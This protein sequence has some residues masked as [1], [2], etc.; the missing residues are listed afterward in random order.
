[1]PPGSLYVVATPLGNLEDITLRALRV[2]K[3]VDWVAAE[4]T[5]HTRKLFSHYGIRTPLI[6][7]HDWVEREKAPRL[8]ER[9]A[10]GESGALVS[11]AGTPGLSDPGFHLVR[12]AWAAGVRVVPVPGPSAVIAA[13]SAAGLP[14]QRFVFEG[15]LPARASSRRARLQELANE[16]RTLVL[17]ETARRLGSTLEDMANVWGGRTVVIA[18]ELTKRFE[19][20]LRGT[21]AEL[22]QKIGERRHEVRGEVTIVAE[23][24]RRAACAPAAPQDWQTALADLLARGVS[25]RDAARKVAQEY[26]ITRREVY[27][28]GLRQH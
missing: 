17:F 10:G 16:P 18:R 4:D 5:R 26:G 24:A 6:A 20:F 11:D 28:F 2:L 13:L 8:V 15:F 23:G 27:A 1:M 25:L 22:L 9:L 14:A 19:E 3:E 7:Y 12:F 21:P